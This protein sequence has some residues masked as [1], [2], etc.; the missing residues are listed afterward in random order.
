MPSKRCLPF[1]AWTSTARSP[2][3]NF[4]RI[5]A[6]AGRCARLPTM[7]C[8][9]FSA[10][11]L[12]PSPLLCGLALSRTSS[13]DGR[14]RIPQEEARR[15]GTAEGNAQAQP[16]TPHDQR[17]DRRTGGVLPWPRH[18]HVG[19]GSLA[20]LEQY[21][22]R[23]HGTRLGIIDVQELQPGCRG[24]H[25]RTDCSG[26]EER[27][28]QVGSGS[29][30]GHHALHAGGRTLH[31][32]R[33]SPRPRRQPDRRIHL[34]RDRRQSGA[35]CPWRCAGPVQTRGEEAGRRV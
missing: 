21:R 13:T 28:S 14:S 18:G 23:A 11:W 15:Q 17:F 12:L 16:T 31:A 34:Q 29:G 2:L 35:A 26:P 7:D 33:T 6:S 22:Q 19:G 9:P 24:S 27:H 4:E 1:L 5:C 10:W 8:W 20:C 3:R 25:Q 30:V 32:G